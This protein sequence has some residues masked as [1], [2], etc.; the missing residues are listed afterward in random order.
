[1][2]EEYLIIRTTNKLE[3]SPPTIP[4]GNDNRSSSEGVGDVF[5]VGSVW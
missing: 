4:M 3:T 5:Y 1:M 2:T